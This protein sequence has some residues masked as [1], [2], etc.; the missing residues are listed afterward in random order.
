MQQVWLATTTHQKINRKVVN[1]QVSKATT[2]LQVKSIHVCTSY[3]A[4][5]TLT[6]SIVLS[7]SE[8]PSEQFF[9]L[10]QKTQ[11]CET[12]CIKPMFGK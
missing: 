9:L 7:I 3:Y 12:L 11:M 6:S 4:S 10:K 8:I 2:E 5:H 1:V